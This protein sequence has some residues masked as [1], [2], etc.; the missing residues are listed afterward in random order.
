[1]KLLCAPTFKVQKNKQKRKMMKL[2]NSQLKSKSVRDL[3]V[4]HFQNIRN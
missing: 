2:K 3:N 4:H 1:M